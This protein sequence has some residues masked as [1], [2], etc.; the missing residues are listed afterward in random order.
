MKHIVSTGAGLVLSGP[1]FSSE[2]ASES[3]QPTLK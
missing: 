2:I 3:T 1:C